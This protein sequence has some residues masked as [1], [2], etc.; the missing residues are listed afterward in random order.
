MGCSASVIAQP[1][2]EEESEAGETSP[3]PRVHKKADRAAAAAEAESKVTPPP[4]DAT[5][6]AVEDLTDATAA[7]E[8][9]K[10]ANDSSKQWRRSSEPSRRMLRHVTHA[11]H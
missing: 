11:K 2:A 6:D 5:E 9:A 7:V 8:E 10:A 1:D 3:A 4:V